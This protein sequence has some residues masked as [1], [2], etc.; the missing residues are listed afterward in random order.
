VSAINVPAL[1]TQAATVEKC[2]TPLVRFVPVLLKRLFSV[3]KFV[4]VLGLLISRNHPA[5]W[6]TGRQAVWHLLRWGVREFTRR[7][8]HLNPD[9]RKVY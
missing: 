7:R 8:A 4:A 6:P 2:I 1:G 3:I 5:T 9:T